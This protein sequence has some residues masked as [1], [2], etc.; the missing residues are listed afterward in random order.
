MDCWGSEGVRLLGFTK[1]CSLETFC[2]SVI[3]KTLYSRVRGEILRVIWKTWF[4]CY[5]NGTWHRFHR[6]CQNILRFIYNQVCRSNEHWVHIILVVLS[7]SVTVLTV[8]YAHVISV[9]TFLFKKLPWPLHNIPPTQ[10]V[11]SGFK[12]VLGVRHW[13]VYGTFVIGYFLVNY[14]HLYNTNRYLDFNIFVYTAV[15]TIPIE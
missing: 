4:C 15:K 13:R 11:F 2:N 7:F 5:Q 3:S 14:S 12:I 1:A 9:I 8:V 6:T 10:Q